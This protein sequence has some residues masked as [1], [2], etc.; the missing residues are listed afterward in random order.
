MLAPFAEAIVAPALPSPGQA[1][2]DI[3]CGAGAL[4]LSIKASAANVSVT[5]SMFLFP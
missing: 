1:V 4:S 5:G 2:I 3:G